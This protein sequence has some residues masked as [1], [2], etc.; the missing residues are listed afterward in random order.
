[1]IWIGGYALAGALVGF[2]AGML[3]IGGAREHAHVG[4][5]GNGGQR[6]AAKTHGTHRL[7]VVQ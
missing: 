1:V 2:L 4:N 5:R 3:G 6:F 7:E